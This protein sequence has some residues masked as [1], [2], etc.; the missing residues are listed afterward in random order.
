ME[1]LN[2]NKLINRFLDGKITFILHCGNDLRTD[3]YERFLKFIENLPKNGR[4]INIVFLG[5]VGTV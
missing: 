3:L 4:T 1:L 5:T 2:L